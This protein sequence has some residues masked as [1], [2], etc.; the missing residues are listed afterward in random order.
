MNS[1]PSLSEESLVQ[2]R[3]THLEM[4]QDIIARLSGFSANA[5]NFCI[6]VLAALVAVAFQKPVPELVW[7]G[8]AV[9]L[10]FAL[11]DAYYLAQEKRF[12]DLYEL[13]CSAPLSS[14]DDISLK[15]RS[16]NARRIGA[17]FFSWS[18]AGVYAA[19]LVGMSILLYIASHGPAE[20]RPAG[21]HR[22]S[23]GE[24]ATS[25]EP[26]G[27]PTRGAAGHT[28]AGPKPVSTGGRT[29]AN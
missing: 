10:L 29:P 23:A 24:P 6:T 9:P 13:T 2:M 26:F 1:P 14:A 25:G 12:R 27:V 15:P 3:L 28:E 19:L 16:L 21:N 20:H 4:I 22:P 7:A 11:L 18:V 8:V 17:A 5:K